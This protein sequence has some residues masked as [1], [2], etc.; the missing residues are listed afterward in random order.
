MLYNYL[1]LNGAVLKC[2]CHFKICSCQTQVL[3]WFISS[4]M[5][6][7]IDGILLFLASEPL[8]GDRSLSLSKPFENPALF[9]VYRCLHLWLNA[10]WPMNSLSGSHY[11]ISRLPSRSTWGSMCVVSPSMS[12]LLCRSVCLPL[13]ISFSLTSVKCNWS[14]SLHMAH[15]HTGDTVCAVAANCSLCSSEPIPLFHFSPPSCHTLP[16]LSQLYPSALSTTTPLFFTTACRFTG[17]FY[18]LVKSFNRITLC[19]L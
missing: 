9:L 5:Q 7:I 1:F 4:C 16:I 8:I 18:H 12:H 11:F 13:P 2:G 19:T 10:F 6:Y 17:L 3:L 14:S 15:R